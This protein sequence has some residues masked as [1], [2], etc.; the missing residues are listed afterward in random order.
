MLRANV[1][2][3]ERAD[4]LEAGQHAEHPVIAPARGLRVQVATDI[5]RQG[6]GIHP[7]AARE[8]VAHLV[9]AHTQT[10]RLA[11]FLEQRAALGIL[12]GQRL[13]VVAARDTRPDLGHLVDRIPKP[14]GVDVHVRGWCGHGKLPVSFACWV[15]QAWRSFPVTCPEIGYAAFACVPLHL[16]LID[17]TEP[18]QPVKII[19]QTR[20][21]PD[22][23]SIDCRK[24]RHQ[25]RDPRRE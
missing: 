16:V 25:G 12:V 13:P 15:H 9:E 6:L 21:L 11:P 10:R 14:F 3:V 2:I 23:H 22:D 4:D 20:A 8:H 5:D 17:A 24:I 7:L 19:F 18:D 1:Q